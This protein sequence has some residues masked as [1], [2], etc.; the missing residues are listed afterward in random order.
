MKQFVLP[1]FVI[2]AFFLVEGCSS[3]KKA[4]EKGN[5]YEAVMKS[6]QRLRQKPD[7]S[8]SLEALQSA[9]PMAVEI[10]EAD[11]QNA[12]ASDAPFKYKS[13]ISS[14]SQINQ[15]YEQ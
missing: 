10:L 5:Y 8:K 4:Y 3:G 14:Y 15:M 2:F 12:I 13:A 1:L 11:A 7:H 9:Y 6:V